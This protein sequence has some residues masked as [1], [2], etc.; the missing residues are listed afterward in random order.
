MLSRIWHGWTTP[1]NAGAYES[2][3]KRENFVGIRD[4]QIQI[5]EEFNFSGGISVTRWSS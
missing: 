4:R 1:S 2:L 3:L 5:I